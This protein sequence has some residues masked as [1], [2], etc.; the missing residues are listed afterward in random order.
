MKH[1]NLSQTRRGRFI[2]F[3]FTAVA[4]L[5]LTA[6]CT[7]NSNKW[8]IGD[9]LINS[10]AFEIKAGQSAV[11]AG[12]INSGNFKN[13][14]IKFHVTHSEGAKASFWFHSDAT[15]SKGYSILIGNPVDDRRRSGSLASVRNLYNLVP[16]SF[17]LEVK[18]EGKRIAVMINGWMVVDYLEPATPFRTAVNAGQLLTSGLIGFR[19]ESGTLNVANANI[20]SLT[21]NLPNYP[22]GREPIDERDDVLIRLQQRNFPVIDYHVHWKR[23]L[24]LKA[25]YEKSLAD[26]YE[27][28]AATNCGIGGF[29]A[30]NDNQIKAFFTNEFTLPPLFYGMQGE[31]REW[32]KTFS[33]EVRELFDYVFT[34]ALTFLDH[35]GRRTQL[36]VPGTI[37]M[38]IPEQEYM[39]MI[40]ERTLKIIN[41][42]PIDFLAS[43]TRL[44]D[45]MMADYDKC[46]TDARVAKLIKALKDNNVAMEINSV[47]KVPSARI[48]RAAKAA[49]VKFTL[50]TNNNGV[51]ELDRL[52]YSLRMVEECGLTIDD[53]WFPKAAK[54]R[55]SINLKKEEEKVVA[56]NLHQPK[57]V[58][59]SSFTLD[60]TGGVAIPITDKDGMISRGKGVSQE[61]L[62]GYQKIVNKYLE[63]QSTGNPDK[64]D[65]FYWKSDSLSEE[66]W[67]RLYAI[68]VQM[69]Y[70]QQKEQMIN[71]WGPSPYYEKAYPPNQGSY[72]I[73]VKDKNCKIQIDDEKV[74]NSVLNSYKTTDF[75]RYSTS[76][77]FRSGGR[78]DEYRVD[79]WTE[80]GYKKFSKQLYEQP[81]SID[82][83]LEIEPKIVFLMEKDDNK[84]TTIYLDP[85]PRYGWLMSKITKISGDTVYSYGS[86]NAPSPT[87]FHSKP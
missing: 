21:D 77:L 3:F 29:Q 35:K 45:V 85:E 36:W 7:G 34:D 32:P 64:I 80:A 78:T 28:G 37:F 87:T 4:F 55:Y 53:M 54:E 67:T 12:D 48:I 41:E 30:S 76:K 66:D 38:D 49:G 63:K 74:E 10:S 60:G 59:I 22:D 11:Y 65:K 20:T 82:Q 31:G 52:A 39:D 70:D 43:P 40:M 86:E 68:Y 25:A 9:K 58:D 71:F 72:D 23:G 47:S 75:F 56:S 84:P 33:K 6:N 24:T 79:L 2:L 15:L 44:S 81:V 42:E 17:D 14:D 57:K 18:V 83:L 26:G 19:V 69:T 61:M 8:K 16:S 1:E 51:D 27:F 73:W 13:F 46:W 50:G 5:L 62:S